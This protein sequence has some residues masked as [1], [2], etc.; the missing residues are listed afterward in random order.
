MNN[1][2]FQ[3]DK[4]H[5]ISLTCGIL[6]MTQMDLSMRQKQ[7][8]DIENTIVVGKGVGGGGQGVCD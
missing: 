4:C 7:L 3:N 6:N 2:L 1:N 8:T 5:V